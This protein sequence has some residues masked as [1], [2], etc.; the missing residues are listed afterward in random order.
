MELKKI[1]FATIV[2]VACLETRSLA[3][4]KNINID[5]IEPVTFPEALLNYNSVLQLVKNMIIESINN[6]DDSAKITI[7]FNEN[8]LHA[9]NHNIEAIL[10]SVEGSRVENDK[11]SN[12]VMIDVNQKT[13]DAHHGKIWK[14]STSELHISSFLIPI[15]QTIKTSEAKNYAQF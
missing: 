13:I 8:I 1:N 5:I 3:S 7:K 10:F 4:N 11:N 14:E 12:A 6:S 15:K 9:N 2:G